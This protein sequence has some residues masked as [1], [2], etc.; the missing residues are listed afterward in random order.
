MHLHEAVTIRGAEILV[1]I[2]IFQI[3][4]CEQRYAVIEGGSCVNCFRPV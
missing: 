4:I 2:F 1:E 3:N